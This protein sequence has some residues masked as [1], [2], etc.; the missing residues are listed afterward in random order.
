[1]ENTTKASNFVKSLRTEFAKKK[2]VIDIELLSAEDSPCKVT[3][4]ISTGCVVLDAIMG[5]GVPIGRM[6]EM[7]GEPSSGKSLIAA[8]IAATAQDA[9]ILVAYADTETTVSDAMMRKLGVNVDELIYTSPDTVEDV[10]EFFDQAIETKRKIDPDNALLLIWD[11][12]AATSSLAEMEKDYGETGYLTQARIISQSLRKITRK[13]SK[14]RVA[15]LFLN[16]TR[17]KIGVM[18]GDKVTT[19]G[20]KAV[21]FHASVR[22]Q[23]I[24]ANK[25]KSVTGKHKNKIVGMNTRAVVV[26]NKVAMPFMDALLPIYFG[27]AIDD[28][29]ASYLWLDDN[30]FINGGGSWR[31]IKLREEEVKFQKKEWLDIYDKYYDEI[32]DIIMSSNDDTEDYGEVVEE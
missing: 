31:T 7:F 32:S 20:G 17:E 12:I 26:K 24:L 21:A 8:Q 4:W 14:D 29:E 16:Q 10:F 30:G 23:L 3:E 19:F 1:M 13:I 27:K 22:V 5:G 28:V 6:V 15:L 9:G 18:F 2:R 25:L 11:S